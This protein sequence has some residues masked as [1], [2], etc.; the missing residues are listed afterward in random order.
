MRYKTSCFNPTL[1]KHDLKRFW[2]LPVL[3]FAFFALVMFPDYYSSMISIRSGTVEA[4]S[5]VTNGIEIS[6]SAATQFVRLSRNAIY[7]FGSLV[8]M[9]P[10]FTALAS[11]LLV[12]QHIHGRKQIQF[13]HGLPLSRRCIYTT[14]AVTGYLM[15]LLPM[16]AAELILM[17]MA[18]C[19]GGEAFPALQ[20]MGITIAS[21][22]MYYAIAI[23]ACVLAG[24]TFGAVLLYAGM[25]CFV[26]ALATGG[27]GIARFLLYGFD[28]YLL[29]E[30]L[31]EWLTPVWLL[32]DSASPLYI[33]EELGIPYGFPL[34]PFLIYGLTGLGLLVLGGVLYQ[35]RRAE[36]AGEMISFP[37]IRGLCKTLVS[38]M[39]G[40][41]GTVA[42]VALMNSYNDVTFPVVLILV[43]VLMAIGWIAAEMVI[44]KT[45]RVF[46]KK[47]MFQCLSLMV[48]MLL[49]LTGAKLDVFGYVNRTP[50]LTQVS[51]AEVSLHGTVVE[52]YPADAL[53]FH[54]TVLDNQDELSNNTAYYSG[55]NISLRYYKGE[56]DILMSRSYYVPLDIDNDIMQS[57]LSIT[58]KPEYVYKS[59]FERQDTPLTEELIDTAQI[60]SHGSYD[61]A[62]DIWTPYL[63]GR[64]MNLMEGQLN[65]T[66]EEGMALHEAIVQ[67]IQEGNLPSYYRDLVC[68]APECYGCLEYNTFADAYDPADGTY[69][70]YVSS[71]DVNYH[72]IDI[73]PSMTN[74]LEALEDL[75]VTVN[76]EALQ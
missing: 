34:M 72:R 16:L 24:Q 28:E 3:I 75:G 68:D 21:F 19:M 22:T 58:A 55:Y 73:Y 60:Y 38:L 76:P 54:E 31:S 59:W 8:V 33:G 39:A 56:Y 30:V 49:V 62:S 20:L 48:L 57:F 4:V 64:N 32:L 44:R 14:S 63:Q 23:L 5:Y 29:L 11:A 52:I 9:V 37:F 26:V 47:P 61:E 15:T 45:F 65:L 7:G 69:L 66:N 50:D 36:T 74:T 17:I 51:T 40:L 71:V 12:M 41:I 43:L 2:P 67:D 42:M 1:A 6:E 10:L 27:A 46:Q 13:Y 53:E 18:P 25:N 35:I 70:E